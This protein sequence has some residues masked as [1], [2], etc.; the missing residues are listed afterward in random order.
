MIMRRKKEKKKGEARHTVFLKRTWSLGGAGRKSGG[1]PY[2]ALVAKCN[3]QIPRWEKRLLGHLRRV[4]TVRR[5]K[6]KKKEKAGRP[7]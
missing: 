6:P 5:R 2:W 7:L 1:L 3:S 4:G